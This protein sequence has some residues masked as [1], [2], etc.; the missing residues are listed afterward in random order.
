MNC[1][2]GDLAVIVHSRNRVNLGKVVRVTRFSPG[3]PFVDMAPMDSWEFEGGR[4]VAAIDGLQV[5]AIPDAW[6][7]PIRDIDGPDE[8]LT[9]AGKPQAVTA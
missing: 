1:R 8:T 3:H 4:V 2:Q 6:L 5:V 7:R 9:W